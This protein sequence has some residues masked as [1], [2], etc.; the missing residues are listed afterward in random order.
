[1]IRG[2]F[3]AQ[4][5][6][7][8]RRTS[9]ITYTFTI[10]IRPS[11]DPT[12]RTRVFAVGVTS[13][14]LS[15][16]GGGIANVLIRPLIDR[17]VAP[18]LERMINQMTATTADDQLKELGLRRTPSAVLNARN[19]VVLPSG[20]AIQIA[21]SD[22]LDK[23]ITKI[24]RNINVTVSPTAKANVRQNYQFTV[25]YLDSGMP[26]RNATTTLHN[27][28]AHG[29]HKATTKITDGNGI[30]EYRDVILRTHIVHQTSTN[31]KVIEVISPT[32]HVNASSDH[33]AFDMTLLEDFTPLK[34]KSS[35]R[36]EVTQDTQNIE[37]IV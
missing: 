30:A 15:I 7:F 37:P 35:D 12:D 29:I 25:T 20:I 6:Y 3:V 34:R 18:L 17:L 22:L 31:N 33:Y 1:M 36:Q 14:I 2:T 5:F 19:V 23:A 13:T 16:A 21:V 9:P 28:D 10:T 8:F 24:P 4:Q 32:F 11:G 27:F 26:V